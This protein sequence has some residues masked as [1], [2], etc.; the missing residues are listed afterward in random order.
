M[1]GHTG[2]LGGIF[3]IS[4]RYISHVHGKG[5]T[6]QKTKQ[7]FVTVKVGKS[8]LPVEAVVGLPVGLPAPIGA[9]LGASHHHIGKHN[10]LWC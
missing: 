6:L 8:S 3:H 5:R 4:M 9:T 10:T 7:L 2:Q 1:I